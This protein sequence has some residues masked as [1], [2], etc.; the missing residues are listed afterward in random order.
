M[1]SSSSWE[2]SHEW[3]HASV[4]ETGHYYHTHIILPRSLQLLKLTDQSDLLDIGCG[5]GVLLRNIPP[6]H[7]YVGLDLAPT[8]IRKAQEFKNPRFA[9][10]HVH[11][12][13]KPFPKTL[14]SFTH[15]CSLLSLQNIP[16]PENVFKHLGDHLIPGAKF[17]IVMNHPCFRIP[18]Q[19]GWLVQR[20]KKLQSRRLDL[21]MSPLKIP[22]QTHPSK[23]ETSPLTWSY[24]R[25]LS[26]YSKALQENGFS[27]TL[28][29]EWCSGKK[30]TGPLAGME[31]RARME[32]P[33][34]IALLCT[35]QANN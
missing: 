25:P 12:V 24:H 11:D 10:F 9:C 7:S 14:P 23:K 6:I 17:L 22:I 2:S 28:I 4:G 31:N 35:Y 34:F 27:I 32:F 15:A 29:E 21:Y 16:E 18:R 26:F 33:L 19:S 1:K 13:T 3:Y 5:Q 30:S 8:L 20:E